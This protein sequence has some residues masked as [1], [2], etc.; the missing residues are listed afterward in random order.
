MSK[1]KGEKPR[2]MSLTD[3]LLSH[4]AQ[5][6]C[7]VAIR[8]TKAQHFGLDEIQPEQGLTNRQRIAEEL[9]D[10]L[11][12]VDEM[13]EIEILVPFSRRDHQARI[14]A[15]IRKAGQF[16]DY[17]RKLGRLDGEHNQ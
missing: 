7:E 11:A 17:S 10:L 5:E 9:C 4:L 16:R 3:Y 6:C 12:I 14:S 1:P 2:P 15:K 8:C 13:Q